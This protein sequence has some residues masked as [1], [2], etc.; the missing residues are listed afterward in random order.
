MQDFELDRFAGMWYEMARSKS[1]QRWT[2]NGGGECNIIKFYR[3]RKEGMLAVIRAYD[4]DR[5]QVNTT[6]LKDLMFDPPNVGGKAKLANFN[7]DINNSS[8]VTG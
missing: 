4:D 8:N 1:F 2:L 7:K 3:R 6:L 5:R